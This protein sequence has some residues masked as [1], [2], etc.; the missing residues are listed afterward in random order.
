MGSKDEERKR[1]QALIREVR[2]KF[3]ITKVVCTKSIKTKL[4]DTYVGMSGGFAADWESTQDDNAHDMAEPSERDGINTSNLSLGE[5]RIA[6]LL[7]GL[8][9]DRLVVERAYANGE[10]SQSEARDRITSVE[11]NYGSLLLE[12]TTPLSGKAKA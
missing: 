4:G 12:E 5:S 9:V 10:L 1:R 8:H 2:D 11:Q 6:A 7:L 3:R